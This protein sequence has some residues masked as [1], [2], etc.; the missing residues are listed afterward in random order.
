MDISWI[1][2]IL[3][4]IISG[5]AEFVPVSSQAH[6]LLIRSLFG[7]GEANSVLDFFVHL[8]M[9]TG[10]LITSGNYISHL[11]KEYNLS[12]ST[13]RRRKREVNMQAVCDVQFVKAACIPML[14]GF[15]VY[16]K[17]M[18]WGN[19]MPIVALCLLLNGILLHIPMYLPQ[20]NKDSRYL[21][22]FDALAFGLFSGLSVLPGFSRIG[23]GCSYGIARGTD[24]KYAYQWG[25]ILSIPALIALLCF[26]V[27]GMFAA[28]SMGADF[29]YILKCMFSGLFSYVGTSLAITL[30]KSMT[31]QSGLS[32]F[33]YY[34]WGA[35]LFAFIL[36]LY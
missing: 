10:L 20:G 12:K 36:Y 33:S 9:L 31:R 19:S 8:G 2:A 14:L 32:I 4:G 1:E 21:N 29:L 25:L 11:L 26:D 27:I 15:V 7:Q 17:T 35:A 28:G 5:L 6:Q 24:P 13:R 18:H 23:M 3:Y 16:S 34:C 22:T 30:L